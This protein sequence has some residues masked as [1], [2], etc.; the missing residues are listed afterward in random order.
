LAHA[1]VR[2]IAS[3]SQFADHVCMVSSSVSEKAK[4]YQQ[5]TSG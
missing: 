3:R 5:R 1:S 4:G 2:L